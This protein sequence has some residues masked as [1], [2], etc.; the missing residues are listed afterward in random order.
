MSRGRF[1]GSV[2]GAALVIAA[3]LNFLFP[4]GLL[5]AETEADRQRLWLLMLWTSGVLAI[6]FG[7]AGL[8]N[9]FSAIGFRDVAEHGS[10]NAA[11][12][13]KRESIRGAGSGFYNFAGWTVSMG[14]AL[15]LIYFVVWLV[16]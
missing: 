6:C 13:A 14:L 11:V 9:A 8:L 2:A 10:L 7:S 16:T 3:L 15:V 12:E 5:G 1:W 4:Y